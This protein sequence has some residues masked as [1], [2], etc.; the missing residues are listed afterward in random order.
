MRASVLEREKRSANNK[1]RREEKTEKRR[2]GSDEP[3]D[4]EEEPEPKK[5]H[6]EN[7]T[8]DASKNKPNHGKYSIILSKPGKKE[9][10]LK[11]MT[12]A[13]MFNAD[14]SSEE[15][16]MPPE[17]RMRMRNIGKDTPT[18]AGPNSFGKTG[19]GFCNRQRI[20]EKELEARMEAVSGDNVGN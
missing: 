1:D 17:A 20:I 18:A 11:K 16:E 6:S 12:V 4:P 3:Y 14:S 10:V 15:D 5:K 9:P 13:N 7:K 19:M 8:S 2:H